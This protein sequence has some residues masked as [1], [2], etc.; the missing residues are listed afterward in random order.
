[1]HDLINR[2]VRQREI[3]PPDRLAGARATVIGVG[4]IGRQ[5]ALQLAAVGV[6]WM[7]LIDPDVISVENLACQGFCEDDLGR[8]KVHATAE[9]C[10]RLNSRLELHGVVRR[11]RRSDS[12]GNCAFCCVDSIATRGLIWQA[13]GDRVDLFA[14]G[15]MTAEVLRV[16]VASDPAS[17]AHYPTTLFTAG[18][19]YQGA[20][21]AKTTIFCANIAA[22]LMLSAFAK[23]LRGMAVD[24]DLHVNLLANEWSLGAS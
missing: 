9:M 3:I 4:S 17:R 2:D 1:M 22:G 8:A 14:D 12:V 13:L 16:V 24:A 20:C 10:H 19:A 7:Q 21:T 18:S 5:V 11:F 23:Y 6:P 15:R